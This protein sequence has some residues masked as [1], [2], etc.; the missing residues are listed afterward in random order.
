MHGEGDLGRPWIL[1]ILCQRCYFSSCFTF[2]RDL[3]LKFAFERNCFQKINILAVI[4]NVEIYGVSRNGQVLFAGKFASC[5]G[6]VSPFIFHWNGKEAICP[7]DPLLPPT[8]TYNRRL[9][10]GEFL[11]QHTSQKRSTG[12][13]RTKNTVYRDITI[14]NASKR[15]RRLY[16]RWQTWSIW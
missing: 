2:Q 9:V 10:A 14:R 11:Q 13:N 5:G 15:T 16:H 7:D 6:S 1:F 12:D 3:F 4:E 8:E